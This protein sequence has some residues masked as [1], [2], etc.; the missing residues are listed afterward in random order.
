MISDKVFEYSLDVREYFINGSQ[1][2]DCADLPHR[3]VLGDYGH[4][5]VAECSKTLFECLDVII[6]AAGGLGPL[7]DALD[8][9]F[10]VGVDEEDE[11][12]VN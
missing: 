7:E 12:H 8:H 6:I 3:L 5:L 9:G 4:G 11:G 1:P 10:L 2:I